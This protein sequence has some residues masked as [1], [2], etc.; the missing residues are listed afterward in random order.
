[1]WWSQVVSAREAFLFSYFSSSEFDG[2]IYIDVQGHSFTYTT[3]MLSCSIFTYVTL[4]P[5]L[6]H[7]MYFKI[8]TRA[9]CS[10]L[11]I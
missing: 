11:L 1:M 9:P 8:H 7:G 2:C 5:W 10:F 6:V 3:C 4:R